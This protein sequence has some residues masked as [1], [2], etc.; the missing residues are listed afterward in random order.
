[1]FLVSFDEKFTNLRKKKMKEKKE[2]GSR[3][4]DGCESETEDEKVGRKTFR[5]LFLLNGHS[6][7]A[8]MASSCNLARV[9]RRGKEGMRGE[10]LA[11]KIPNGLDTAADAFEKG[12]KLS[13]LLKKKNLKT[14]ETQK[15]LELSIKSA[16][17]FCCGERRRLSHELFT[18]EHQ[19][20]S[21][22]I[23]SKFHLMRF[24]KS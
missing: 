2:I 7:I 16:R 22:W 11:S 1:M 12:R 20:Y 10:K 21:F 18:R 4:N 13:R 6:E 3:R 14:S 15:A 24:I 23:Q 17:F 9:Q 8:S 19:S 5:Y